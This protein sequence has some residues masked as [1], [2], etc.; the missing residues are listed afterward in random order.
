MDEFTKRR[1][2]RELM[3]ACADTAKIWEQEQKR[4]GL[5]QL[6]VAFAHNQSLSTTEI[7][8]RAWDVYSLIDAE[9]KHD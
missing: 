4:S 3:D 2:E 5:L 7:F 9:S 8:Q 6:A 1:R